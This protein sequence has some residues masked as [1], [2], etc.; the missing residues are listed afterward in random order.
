MSERT[1]G[2]WLLVG[3]SIFASEH[4]GRD[5]PAICR[6]TYGIDGINEANARFIAAAPDM[7]KALERY[8]TSMEAMFDK[9]EQSGL[10][11]GRPTEK[12][13]GPIHQARAALAKAR[14]E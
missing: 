5:Q 1:P 4:E 11:N 3:R 13:D 7:G 6:M 12:K 10:Y 8:V 2:Q 9:I 14:G